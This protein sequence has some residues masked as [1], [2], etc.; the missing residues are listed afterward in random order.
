[1]LKLE[2]DLITFK[3]LGV[4][5]CNSDNKRKIINPI[6][7][8]TTLYTIGF[9]YYCGFILRDSANKNKYY[10]VKEVKEQI[11]RV[12][13]KERTQKVKKGAHKI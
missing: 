8:K 11:K 12:H 6:Y 1:L 2:H 7:D 3:Q 5:L 9:L 13:T 4:V 10:T